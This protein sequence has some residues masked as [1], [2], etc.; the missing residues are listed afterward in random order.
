MH[1]AKS[2]VGVVIAHANRPRRVF[3]DALPGLDFAKGTLGGNPS[4]SMGKTRG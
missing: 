2:I 1:A 4:S 3:K